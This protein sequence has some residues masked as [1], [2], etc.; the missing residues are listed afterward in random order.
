MHITGLCQGAELPH[1]KKILIKK[2]DAE[3]GD[4]LSPVQNNKIF[5]SGLYVLLDY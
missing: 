3:T 4:N 1:L 5:S 2:R